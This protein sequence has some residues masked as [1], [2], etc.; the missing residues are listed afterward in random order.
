[1]SNPY[2]YNALGFV[3]F[4]LDRD[5]K[6]KITAFAESLKEGLGDNFRFYLYRYKSQN[7]ARIKSELKEFLVSIDRR[8]AHCFVPNHATGNAIEKLNIEPPPKQDRADGSS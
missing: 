8:F 6:R 5:Q 1:M 7:P 2:S 3:Y 4:S